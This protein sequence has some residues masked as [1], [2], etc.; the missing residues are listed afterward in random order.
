MQFRLEFR[1]TKTK[2]WHFTR[3][4]LH[5][6]K[7][8]WFENDALIQEKWWKRFRDVP[9]F[10]NVYLIDTEESSGHGRAVHRLGRIL[11]SFFLVFGHRVPI[12]LQIP[13]KTAHIDATTV[14]EVVL[15]WSV[16]DHVDHGAHDRR[17]IS[18][19]PVQQGLQPPGGALAVG[20]Q[21]GEDFA[22]GVG[23]AWKTAESD[24]QQ[25][26]SRVTQMLYMVIENVS[27]ITCS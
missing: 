10:K 11:V 25:L 23:G 7:L 19:Y 6:D 15:E 1:L 27:N 2:F 16:I 20:V 8:I 21:V 22:L 13:I 24:G 12:E 9:G 3:P 5:F 4:H 18:G 26:P 17:R 14:V